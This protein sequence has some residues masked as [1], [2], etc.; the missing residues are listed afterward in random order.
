MEH[1]ISLH[2]LIYTFVSSFLALFPVVNPISDGLIVNRYLSGLSNKDRK[3]II[4]RISINCLFIGLI[5]LIAGHLILL[6][7]NLDIPVIQLA[8]GMLICKT[9]LDGLSDQKNVD[10][11]NKEEVVN[12]ANLSKVQRMIFYPLSFPICIGPGSISVIFTL[13]AN[14][15]EKKDWLATGLN[16]GVITFAITILCLMIYLCCLQS[17]KIIGKLGRSGGLIINKLVSFLTFCIGI[18]IIVTGISKIFHV[19]IM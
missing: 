3:N 5:S 8:G 1:Y 19:N 16:Y 11:D 17:Q 10:N 13:M 18:Q 9:G 15:S 4:R 2:S 12:K 14:Y 7:F 6:L